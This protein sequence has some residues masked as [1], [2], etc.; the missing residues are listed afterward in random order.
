MNLELSK[1]DLLLLKAL[2]DKEWG[3]LRVEIHH[4]RTHDY[5]DFLKQSEKQIDSMRERINAALG[6]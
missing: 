1:E 5:K 4:C 3:V 6:T 2:L